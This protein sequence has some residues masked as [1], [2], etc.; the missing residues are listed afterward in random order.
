MSTP[1]EIAVLK[2]NL[3]SFRAGLGSITI[4][5]VGAA[6]SSHLADDV[7]FLASSGFV[8]GPAAVS[9]AA[10]DALRLRA[11]A[12]EV[13][14]KWLS[15]DIAIVDSVA[16][17]GTTRNW[18]TE[19]WQKGQ[20]K[21]D[22]YAIRVS[23]ARVG[24]PEKSYSTLNAAIPQTLTATVATDAPDSEGQALRG[25]FKAFRT[26]FNNGDLKGVTALF[27]KTVDAIAVFSF[28]DGRAQILTGGGVAAKQG[29]L[30]GQ[31]VINP[32]P[33]AIAGAKIVSGEPKAIRFLSPTV[34]A[35]DGVGQLSGVPAA[36]G[37]APSE[38]KGVYTNYWCK[39]GGTWLI[40]SI[41]PWF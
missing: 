18:F 31:D 6:T 28:L 40:E 41:R 10:A 14:T 12:Q 34:A 30:M 37:F 32:A 4:F 35:V 39:T 20:D 36:H 17:T 15:D 9:E 26:A 38:M 1:Q 11:G 25:Q 33:D 5:N 21:Q 3:E 22:A 23:R 24:T 16:D 2:S 13:A 8:R 27:S 29:R 7:D 19:V